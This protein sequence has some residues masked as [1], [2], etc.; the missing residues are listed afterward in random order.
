MLLRGSALE[1]V[2][3]TVFAGEDAIT[4]QG[5]LSI[6]SILLHIG[7][8]KSVQSIVQA[9]QKQEQGIQAKGTHHKG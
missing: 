1:N 7:R 5:D 6:S 8:H 3:M 2:P 9:W 4:D